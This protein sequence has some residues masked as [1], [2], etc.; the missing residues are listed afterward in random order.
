M[1]A[2]KMEQVL[3]STFQTAA[4]AD[5]NTELLRSNLGLS[6]KNRIA[7]LAIGRSLSETTYPSGN[8]FGA[9]RPIRGDV[10]FGVEELPLWVALLFTHLRRIDPRAELTLASLQDL[11]KR[12]WSRGITLLMEDWEEAEEN[13]NRFVDILVRRRADL[14]E[15]GA[16][17]LVPSASNEDKRATSA[18]DPR[19]ILINLGRFVDSKD[20]FL[21]RVNGV[22]YSP[23]VAVM[24]QAGSGKTRT[25]LELVGQVHKQS[26]ASVI[27]L[28]LGKGDLANQT[29][30]IRT[31]G[32]RVLRVPE[33][34]IPLDMFH[35]S[36]SSELAASDAIMG[37][38]DSFVKVMQSKAGAV[39]QEAMKDALRPLFSKRKN[40]SLDDISQALRDFYDDRNQKTD[41]VI[42]TISDLTERTIFRP[43]MSPS[44]FFSQ[45]WII[46]FAHAHDT[47][48][49]L[50][51]YL[52]LD[53][54]NTFVKR[55]P[56]APQDFEGHRAVRTILAVD[57]AR[58]LL[59]S[60]HKA[61]SDN[62]RLH[63]SKGLMVTLASQSPDDYDGAGD[64]H[65][66]NI[67]LPICFKTNAAS[68]QVL[69]NMFRG[70]VS[71][72]SLPPGVFMT[73]RDTKPVK[74]KAF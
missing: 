72:A 63:R 27:L 26:G 7:R 71:F 60:R 65:L 3:V 62:I 40:I 67:G 20:P 1:S 2:L 36:D 17:S 37:F 25:M 54:L 31:I 41:S 23:H 74:I 16:T 68:N 56:E 22:G 34:P 19:P 12:H 51:A 39:Q 47:Q 28:D 29:E 52:L 14:P 43:A 49:N 11:V 35:G 32:A 61:L 57:E 13:Y 58:H 73:I 6:A 48:K 42:S 21:W 69:Q 59:A 66:E 8:L 46:T 4:E 55:S 45:S 33:E 9:G 70:K 53:A 50:A 64:D 24:G 38:R 30:F 44:S 15:T 18:G 10:L 5:K